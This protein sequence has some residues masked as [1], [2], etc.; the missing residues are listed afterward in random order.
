M[1]PVMGGA[2]VEEERREGEG[3]QLDGA[4]SDPE[5]IVSI[6]AR[7]SGK[8]LGAALSSLF[9]ILT[10]RNLPLLR[11]V[12]PLTEQPSLLHIRNHRRFLHDSR[13]KKISSHF[14]D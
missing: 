6:S 12:K 10:P 3:F 9:A 4:N 1:A 13:K 7:W 2:G 5:F 14:S 11:R 8:E